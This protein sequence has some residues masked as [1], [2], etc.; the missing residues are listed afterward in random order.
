MPFLATMILYRCRLIALDDAVA[1]AGLAPVDH[2]SP[3]KLS[4][5]FRVREDA[6]IRFDMCSQTPRLI[7]N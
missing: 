2:D 5:V 3:S 7:V 1:L 4:V 6:A